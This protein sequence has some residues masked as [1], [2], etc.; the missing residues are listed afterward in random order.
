MGN[1]GFVPKLLI[2]LV[3]LLA[4]QLSKIYA[5]SLNEGIVPKQWEEADVSAIFKNE[6]KQSAENYRPVR[7]TSHVCKVLESIIRDTIIDNLHKYDLINNMQHGFVKDRSCLN[8]LLE[9]LETITDLFDRRLP[10]DIV[11]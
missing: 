11:Y 2:E 8:N 10:I 4:S 5:K 9:F 3:S 6:S 7:L 1:D